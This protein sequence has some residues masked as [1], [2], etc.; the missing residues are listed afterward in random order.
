[1]ILQVLRGNT[2]RRWPLLERLTREKDLRWIEDLRNLIAALWAITLLLILMLFI[3]PKI[4]LFILF[5]ISFFAIPS[6]LILLA[7]FIVVTL[8][9]GQIMASEI[10]GE[11]YT[12]LFLT[13]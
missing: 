2:T 7:L 6:F 4:F 12:L 10:Q 5:S 11:R 1:M 13:N 3:A 8:S 9:A